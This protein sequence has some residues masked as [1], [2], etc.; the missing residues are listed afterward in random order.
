MSLKT[1]EIVKKEM[2]MKRRSFLKMSAAAA[3]SAVMVGC[4][5]VEVTPEK[6]A[7]VWS[8]GE[9]PDWTVNNEPVVD[10][11]YVFVGQSFKHASER[12]AKTSSDLDAKSKS[13]EFIAQ[14]IST[15][16]QTSVTGDSATSSI[17]DSTVTTNVSQKAMANAVVKNLSI[18]SR[19]I[20]LWEGAGGKRFYKVWSMAALDEADVKGAL[21]ILADERQYAMEQRKQSSNERK[22]E[23]A[24]NMKAKEASLE[25]QKQKQAHKLS[26]Q[27]RIL[28]MKKRKIEL[29][30]EVQKQA[31][32]GVESSELSIKDI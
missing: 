4:S 1:P 25:M 23:H 32:S 29:E 26:V 16:V 17:E 8:S 20:E 6:G 19:Y 27:D 7:M 14:L 5:S 3:I 24:F 22:R 30:Y 28:D 2:V 31:L 12:M 18:K 11:K 9:R 15:D 10:G 13:A 21:D